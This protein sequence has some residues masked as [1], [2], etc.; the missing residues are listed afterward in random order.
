MV[1]A[2]EVEGCSSMMVVGISAGGSMVKL[3]M[4]QDVFLSSCFTGLQHFFEF[5]R[6]L[7]YIS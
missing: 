1:F 2:E 7:L 6:F 5:P 4:P 3:D